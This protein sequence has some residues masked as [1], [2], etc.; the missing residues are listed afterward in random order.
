M[1]LAKGAGLRLVGVGFPGHFLV[2]T[3][4]VY[5]ARVLDPFNGGAELDRDSLVAR[6]LESGQPAENA[7]NALRAINNRAILAR[8]LRNLLQVYVR[9]GEDLR[10]LGVVERLLV[11]DPE[12]GEEWSIRGALCTRLGRYDEGEAALERALERLT[13]PDA[14]KRV[15]EERARLLYW[16]ARRN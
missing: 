5:P 10:A 15:E 6:L 14:R 4:G 16:K 2:K 7:E 11:L 3:Q 12:A 1:E 8:L 13:D 9:G